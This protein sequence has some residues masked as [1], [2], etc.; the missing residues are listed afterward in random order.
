MTG[1][2]ARLDE[3]SQLPSEYP[4]WMFTRQGEVRRK[5]IA[6]ARRP[7]VSG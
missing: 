6:E 3:V 7:S 1:E 2:L 4:G 5:Q